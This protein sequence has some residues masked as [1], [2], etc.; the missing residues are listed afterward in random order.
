MTY[1][2]KSRPAP[3]YNFHVGILKANK[4]IYAEACKVLYDQNMFVEFKSNLTN[5]DIDFKWLG[6]PVVAQNATASQFVYCV[7]QIELKPKRVGQF[8]KGTPLHVC[9]YRKPLNT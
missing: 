2:S 5:E 4:T 1:D 8:K 3:V 9:I 7:L 6:V